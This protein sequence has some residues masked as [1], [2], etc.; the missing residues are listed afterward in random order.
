MKYHDYIGRS[1]QLLYFIGYDILL[2]LKS[3]HIIGFILMDVSKRIM[4]VI[5]LT[6]F[7]IRIESSTM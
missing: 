2:V 6:D 3:S 5:A 1:L 7:T 4:K